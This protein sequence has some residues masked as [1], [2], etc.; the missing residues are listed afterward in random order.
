MVISI[1]DFLFSVRKN[2]LPLINMSNAC[3]KLLEC[4]WSK[5]QRFFACNR[6]L[7]VRN[8]Q[9]LPKKLT[10]R[11]IQTRFYRKATAFTSPTEMSNK[12]SLFFSWNFRY[13][14]RWFLPIYRNSGC[15]NSPK[16]LILRTYYDIQSLMSQKLHP[17]FP[18]TRSQSK[19]WHLYRSYPEKNQWFCSSQ[20]NASDLKSPKNRFSKPVHLYKLFLRYNCSFDFL[21]QGVNL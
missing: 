19:V 20:E 6:T 3:F 12:R 13:Q 16:M 15:P 14:K 5:N 11:E 18:L 21:H 1:L 4:F 10:H 17:W 7:V 2:F 8:Y 9:K